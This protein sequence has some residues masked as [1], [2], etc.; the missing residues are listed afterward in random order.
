MDAPNRILIVGEAPGRHSGGLTR[1]RVSE[2]A[3]APYEEWADWQNLIADYPGRGAGKG[4]AWNVVAARRGVGELTPRLAGYDH[5]ILLGRRVAGVII[6]G[7]AGFPFFRWT[8]GHGTRLA[9]IPHTSGIVRF[10]N[11]PENVEAAQRFLAEIVPTTKE[12]PMATTRSSRSSASTTKKKAT[13][14]T[15]AAKTEVVADR[16]AILAAMRAAGEPLTPNEAAAVVIAAGVVRPASPATP[17][18]YRLAAPIYREAKK[19]R[20]YKRV[21]DDKPARYAP[22]DDAP[23]S[24]RSLVAALKA[25]VV[26]AKKKQQAAAA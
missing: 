16:D 2:L 12:A 25:E 9:V 7:G 17:L 10:W 20:F 21:G 23:A 11:D 8:D 1:Q 4:S 5:V 15:P 26:K 3:G 14:S 13:R 24:D 22:T 6:P 19:G 18:D